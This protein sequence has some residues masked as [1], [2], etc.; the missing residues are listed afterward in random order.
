MTPY[1]RI[2]VVLQFK[3]VVR[4]RA[5][6]KQG[7]AVCENFHKAKVGKKASRAKVEQI[8]T[9]EVL[10]KRAG[11]S[12]PQV[13]KVLKIQE[14]IAEGTIGQDVLDQLRNG[15]VS[16]DAVYKEYC[17]GQAPK[18]HSDKDLT[19]RSSS[20]IRLLKMQVARSFQKTE[21]CTSLYDKIIEWA[22][23]RKSGLEE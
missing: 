6:K 12:Y 5:R 16:I 4:E 8:R 7:G 10:G 11:V 22:N 19:E 1:Q 17:K 18:K 15:D 3:G 2:E 9:N 14:K 13:G 21:D 23:A 20:I